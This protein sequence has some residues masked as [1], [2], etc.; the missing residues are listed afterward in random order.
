MNLDRL[1]YGILAWRIKHVSNKNFLFFVSFLIGIVGGLAAVTL[2]SAVHFIHHATNEWI[3]LEENQYLFFLLPLVGIMLTVAFKVFFMHGKLGHGIPNLLYTV[4][5]KSSLVE[6]DKMY[7]HMISGAL[8]VGFGGSV[9]LEAPIVTT[10]SAF[11]SNIGR[12]FHLGYKKRSLLIGCGAAAAIAAIF[13]APIAGV[14]FSLE[15]LLLELSIPAFIP[16][17]ISAITG[18]LVAKLILGDAILFN[19]TAST[20]FALKEVPLF[21]GLGIF[22]GLVSLYFTR[23]TYFSERIIRKVQNTF[24]RALVGGIALG[25][26]LFVFPPLYGEGY[27]VIKGLLNNDTSVIL[28]HNMLLQSLDNEFLLMVIVGALIL[29]KALASAFT[30]SAG[31]NGGIF[32]PSLFLGGIAGFFM[33]RLVND[34]GFLPFEIS[35]ATFVL[36]GMAGVM[37]GVL[38]AP[39][40]AIFL[41]AEITGGYMLFLPLMIVAAISYATITYF[42]PHSLYTKQLALKGHLHSHDKDKSVLTMLKLEHLIEKDFTTVK[43][44][45]T[46]RDLVN[47]VSKSTRNTFPVLNRQKE[48]QGI[49]HLDDIRELMF[50]PN[51]Y[52]QVAIE[53]LMHKPAAF[54][55]M[56]ETMEEAMRK[57]DRTGEWNLPVV[58]EGVYLGFLSKSNIFSKYRNLLIQQSREEN[59]I[60]E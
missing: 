8:T 12:L 7:S 42:E 45:G 38:H 52:D 29:F 56:H 26:M 30:I 16:L 59:E 44:N 15:I 47:A 33:A 23:M 60:I 19:F 46:L 57:F 51:M 32:A 18:T 1:L 39:L 5:K 22:A 11:G 24:Q 4:S 49:I 40:T 28:E 3:P 2:K 55:Y 41:I 20:G 37:S 27:D 25:I 9:G 10:G 54:I 53:D 21:I 14:I 13:N 31:G 6:R 50:K 36:V 34:L 43:V 17:F 58:K 35:E 48:L